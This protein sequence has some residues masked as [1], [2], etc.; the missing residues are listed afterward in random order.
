MRTT[1][2]RLQRQPRLRD[3]LKPVRRTRP[4]GHPC[5]VCR[6]SRE[7]P[8]G[9][10]HANLTLLLYSQLLSPACTKKAKGAKLTGFFRTFQASLTRSISSFALLPLLSGCILSASCWY[11]RFMSAALDPFWTPSTS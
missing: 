4:L 11:A 7:A 5:R 2:P 6:R 3:C 8:A 10:C 9:I 1:R